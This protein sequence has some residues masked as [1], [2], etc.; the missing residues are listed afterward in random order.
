MIYF[1]PLTAIVIACELLAPQT[2]LVPHT[3]LK[4]LLVLV[5]HTTELPQTTDWPLVLVPH[6]TEVPH[7]RHGRKPLTASRLLNFR[8]EGVKPF[9]PNPWDTGQS[10]PHGVFTRGVNGK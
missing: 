9:C 10:V 7:I 8:N 5:P 2:T 4:P 3:T 6:T 1:S